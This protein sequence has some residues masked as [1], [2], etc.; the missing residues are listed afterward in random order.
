MAK[1]K[2]R[3]AKARKSKAGKARTRPRQRP[4][5]EV[6]TPLTGI[7]ALSELLLAA[8]LPDREREWAS[9]L[10]SAAEHLTAFASL[11]VDGVRADAV[12]LALKHESFSPR[13][14]AQAVAATLVAR[15]QAK[16]LEAAN[17]VANNLPDGASGDPVRLRAAIENLIDNAVKFTERGRVEF[18]AAAAPEGDKIRLAFTVTDTGIGLD[19]AE[20]KRLFRPFGQASDEVA[21]RFGG[22][23]LGLTFARRIARAMGGDLSVS[24][25]RGRGSTFRLDVVVEKAARGRAKPRATGVVVARDGPRL[26]VLCAEDNPYGRVILNTILTEFGHSIDFVGSG[27]AAVAAAARGGCDL[28]LMDVTLPGIDGIEAARRIR[29]LPGAAGRVPIIGLSGRSAPGEEQAARAAGMNAYFVKPV[30]P[31][32]LAAAIAKSP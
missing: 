31:A 32:V 20:I 23:G 4:A 7:L 11:V 10:K 13:A 9:A 18:S 30:S 16:G 3:K 24:S 5:H 27:E 28:V 14:L 2:A 21:R 25:T 12:S 29:A 22:A 1:G 19:A 17:T 8:G 6:R 15:A 26:K